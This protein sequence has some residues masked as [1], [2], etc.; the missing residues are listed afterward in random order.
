MDFPLR[1]RF[2]L[3]AFAPQIYVEDASGKTVCYVK[4]K[5]FRL[6]EKVEVFT[7]DTQRHLLATIAADRI[8]DWSA[9]YVFC[10]AS[11]R[12][13]GS[14][15]RRGLRSLWKAHYE[16]C[17]PVSK[18]PLFVIHE[19]NPMVKVLDGLITLIPILGA[20]SGLMFHPR[21][22]ATRA[23]D[24]DIMRLTKQAAIWEGR[25]ELEK[26]ENIP[27]VEQLI[28]ILSFLMMI[29]LEKNRG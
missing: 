12:E 11:G 16:V 17:L 28:L 29:L 7:D 5:L 13:I 26:I 27:D 10:D 20:F 22:A 21:Y 4:Q 15:G 9:R 3:L 8:I 6:R 18:N 2:K 24:E 19:E 14:V 25:F 1:F 23:G